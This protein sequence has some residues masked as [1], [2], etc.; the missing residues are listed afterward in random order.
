MKQRFCH[1]I[2]KVGFIKIKLLFPSAGLYAMSSNFLR[3]QR[4]KKKN[5]FRKLKEESHALIFSK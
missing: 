1:S 5:F 4:F 2:S 3:I